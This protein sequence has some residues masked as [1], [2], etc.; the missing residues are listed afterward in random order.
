MKTNTSKR[1][2]LTSSFLAAFIWGF[3]AFYVNQNLKSGAVQMLSSFT[4]TFLMIKTIVFL[5]NL[6]E[7]KGQKI[8][9]PP[10]IIGFSV[11]FVLYFIHYFAQS[12]DII[13]T[14]IPPVFIGTTF[15]LFTTLKLARS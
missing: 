13:K 5:F 1:Y 15:C 6:F 3:W 14:I 4:I 11:F 7:K 12:S 2:N 10:L 9:F 8:I